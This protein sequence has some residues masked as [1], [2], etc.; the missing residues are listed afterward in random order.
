MSMLEK[1]R[2]EIPQAEETMRDARTVLAETL[3]AAEHV[4][5]NADKM[6]DDWSN[7]LGAMGACLHQLNGAA[8]AHTDAM[9]AVE[10][11]ATIVGAVVVGSLI[12]FLLV[13]V[14]KRRAA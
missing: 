7:A 5:V 1:L 2:P 10:T 3:S 13:G 6:A 12:G 4:R 8:Q 14:R 11:A 9:R